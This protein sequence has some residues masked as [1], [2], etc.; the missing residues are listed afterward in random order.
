MLVVNIS[1]SGLLFLDRLMKKVNSKLS[2]RLSKTKVVYRLIFYDKQY[3]VVRLPGNNYKY[4]EF[5]RNASCVLHLISTFLLQKIDIQL[6]RTRFYKK[7][8][9]KTLNVKS[10][11]RLSIFVFFLID[12]SSI[13]IFFNYLV[14]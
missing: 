4:M 9:R 3:V 11:V 2:S 1:T 14:L 13:V 5:Y 10:T 6:L 8:R 7:N 12:V